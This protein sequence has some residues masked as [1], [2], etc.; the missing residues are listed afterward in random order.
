[1]LVVVHP[2][3]HINWRD[4]GEVMFGMIAGHYVLPHETQL[5]CA[6]VSMPA[7]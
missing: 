3:F 2:K 1:M 7:E 5:E 4:P 6:S